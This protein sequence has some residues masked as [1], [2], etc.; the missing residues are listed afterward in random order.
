[1]LVER[2][3]FDI[4]LCCSSPVLTV[5][6]L[7]IILHH[8]HAALSWFSCTQWVLEGWGITTLFGGSFLSTTKEGITVI[9]PAA[10]PEAF[11]A[12][13]ILPSLCSS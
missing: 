8:R 3:G 13:A 5:E 12:P 4:L 7:S 2:I 1:M 9:S 10:A 11:P 6:G